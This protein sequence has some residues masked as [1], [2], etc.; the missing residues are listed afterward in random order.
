MRRRSLPVSHHHIVAGRSWNAKATVD[1]IEAFSGLRSGTST[2]G[3]MS[4]QIKL[5]REGTEQSRVALDSI[6]VLNKTI[7]HLPF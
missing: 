1:V 4:S 7:E 3:K 2:A 6:T 5:P